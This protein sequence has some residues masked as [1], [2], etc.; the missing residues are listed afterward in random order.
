MTIALSLSEG[1]LEAGKPE[2]AL[3]AADAAETLV[4][5]LVKGDPILANWGEEQQGISRVLKA[6]INATT[7]T[8]PSERAAAL[9]PTLIEAE[10]LRKLAQAR[11]TKL[12]TVRVAAEAALLAGDHVQ[13]GGRSAGGSQV[14]ENQPGHSQSGKPGEL[15]GL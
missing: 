8:S 14:V 15:S 7:A 5:S 3:A 12:S 13:P 9:A 6:R 2:P 10:R 11:P 1:Y 4:G